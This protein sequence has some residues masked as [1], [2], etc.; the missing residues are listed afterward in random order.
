MVQPRTLQGDPIKGS[1]PPM[2]GNCLYLYSKGQICRTGSTN[3]NSDP[4]QNFFLRGGWG[5]V[6]QTNFFQ[7]SGIL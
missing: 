5:Q 7:T 2:W 1:G 3:K 4:V 6:P